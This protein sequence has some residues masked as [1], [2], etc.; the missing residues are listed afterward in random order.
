ML[1]L[2]RFIATWIYVV[3]YKTCR[4]G[5]RDVKTDRSSSKMRIQVNRSICCFRRG[6]LNSEL[7]WEVI[8][9]SRFL[10]PRRH[11][12]SL[13]QSS[14]S[15]FK[16]LWRN[17]KRGCNSEFLPQTRFGMWTCFHHQ[18][19][20][21]D[22]YCRQLSTAAGWVRF[23][24]RCGICVGPSAMGVGFS[25]PNTS[26][27]PANYH[28]SNCSILIIRGWYSRPNSGRRTKWTRSHPTLKVNQ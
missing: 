22:S 27:S 5:S 10:S 4:S 16:C 14:V 13:L 17:N 25:P 20:K 6:C 18:C 15:K 2:L 3:A 24:V 28:S 26:V 7:S 23:Q 9:A 21:K 11:T 12:A 8:L 1:L 19:T